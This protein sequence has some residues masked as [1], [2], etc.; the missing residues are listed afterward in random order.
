MGAQGGMAM[1]VHNEQPPPNE[2]QRPTSW[3]AIWNISL[4]TDE[5][6]LESELDEFDFSS[7]SCIRVNELQ[8]AFLLGY[9]E[10]PFLADALWLALNETK[11][12]I[13]DNGESVR[14][15]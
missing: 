2:P 15:A 5:R 14:V 6:W 11:G 7:D 3:A 8:G 12:F 13:K 4:D 10:F 1:P 9:R